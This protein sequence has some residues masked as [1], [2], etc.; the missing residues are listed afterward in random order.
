[1]KNESKVIDWAKDIPSKSLNTIII[2]KRGSGKTALGFH[3]LDLHHRFS[4]RPLY[5]LR[6]PKQKL[7]P[8][9]I[10][11]AHSLE[12]APEGSVLLIDEA[13]L[14]FN[15]FAFNSKEGKEVAG[16]L[17]LARHKKMSIIFIT[18]HGATLTRDVRRLVDVYL[19]R[20]PSLSQRYDEISII[21]RL[22]QNCFMLFETD[23]AKKKGF[24]IADNNVMEMAYFDL[25]S[26]W[27]DE[28]STAY[29]GDKEFVNLSDLLK[30]EN[31]D[32]KEKEK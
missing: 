3:I 16:I 13:G 4:K 9:H 30:E 10:K 15:Q 14:D 20:E 25:P 23:T 31:K 5:V 2:G 1:M 27:N 19:L 28:I 11:S 6:F 8:K 7:L 12:D 26:Y 24:Y 18:Q 21:K 32:G 29:G 22:Y 17:K